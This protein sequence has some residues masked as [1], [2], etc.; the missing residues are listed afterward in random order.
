MR[1]IANFCIAVR[2]GGLGEEP[3]PDSHL[4]SDAR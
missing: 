2:L 4:M 3:A 1:K